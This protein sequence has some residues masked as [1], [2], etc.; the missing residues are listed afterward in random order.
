M[1]FWLK[2][3]ERYRDCSPVGAR[4]GAMLL[5]QEVVI[6]RVPTPIPT[7]QL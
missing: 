4:F 5:H 1:R 3:N 7:E 6:V 2:V